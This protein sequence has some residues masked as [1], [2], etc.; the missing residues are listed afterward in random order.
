[1]NT[2]IY[3]TI[4]DS[5][6]PF[7]ID[8]SFLADMVKFDPGPVADQNKNSLQKGSQNLPP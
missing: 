3:D 2:Q 5:D 6:S 7:W 8:P 4:T 1:V